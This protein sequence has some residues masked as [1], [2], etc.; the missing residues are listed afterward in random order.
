M[1][2]LSGRET[3]EAQ[4]SGFTSNTEE[5]EKQSVSSHGKAKL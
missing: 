2:E 4:S 3:L 5:N 1:G